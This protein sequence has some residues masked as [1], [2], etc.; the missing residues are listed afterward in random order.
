MQQLQPRIAKAHDLFR[1]GRPADALAC[2]E[3]GVAAGEASAAREL[4]LW[5]LQGLAGPRDLTQ[6]RRWFERAGELGDTV[7]AAIYRAFVAQGTGG[8]AD[9]PGAMALLRAAADTDPEAARQLALIAAMELDPHGVPAPVGPPQVDHA[10]PLVARLPAFLTAAECDYLVARAAPLMQPS[11]I[12]DP[13]SGQQ[14]PNP[15]RTSDGAAFP[16]LDEDPAIHA[17]NRRIATASETD[18]RCGEP[19]Q[20]L[21]YGPGQEYRLHSDALPGAPPAQQRVLTFLIWL[22]D[23]FDGGETQFPRLGLSLRGRKGDGLLFAST[24][25]DGQPD[26]RAVHAGLPVTRRIKSLASRWIRATPLVY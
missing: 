16:L 13:R 6:S 5:R 12:V 15:I 25:A 9:W 19:L 21:R 2:L 24:T 1:A 23:D 10:A 3:D 11:V 7:A 8:P 4:G 14:I 22:N 18:V 26:P 20:V 17:I